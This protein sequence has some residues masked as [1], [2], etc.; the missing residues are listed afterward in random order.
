MKIEVR[1]SIRP[2]SAIILANAVRPCPDRPRVNDKN[3]G[4][5]PIGLTIG[6]SAPTTR[7]VFFTS[8]LSAPLIIV[9]VPEFARGRRR[10]WIAPGRQQWAGPAKR[11][12]RD[13]GDKIAGS[14]G[15]PAPAG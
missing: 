9:N 3:M 12:V 14:T 13:A 7:R 2:F 6:N 1:I 11:R 8:S 10:S 4:V 15:S 5:L